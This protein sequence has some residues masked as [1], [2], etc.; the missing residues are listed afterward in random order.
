MSN[1]EEIKNALRNCNKFLL[2][3]GISIQD[4]CNDKD[5]SDLYCQICEIKVK[6]KHL[7]T[8]LDTAHLKE[9]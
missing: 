3:A 1:S 7:F 9:E 5:I 2:D 8:E 4:Y 6:T